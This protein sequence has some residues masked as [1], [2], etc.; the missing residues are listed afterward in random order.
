[1]SLRWLALALV[2]VPAVAGA[3]DDC[4][5]GA[6]VVGDDRALASLRDATETTCPCASY[7]GG[8]GKNRAAY[9]AC[10]RGVLAKATDVRPE[11]R[12]R[13]SAEQRSTTCGTHKVACGRANGRKDA[14]PTCRITRAGACRATGA[15]GTDTACPQETACTEVVDWTAGTCDDPRTHGRYAAG[16]TVITWTKDSIASPGTPRPLDTVIWYPAPAGSSP[17]G[18]EGG[19]MDAPVDPGGAPY[20][21]VLFSHGSCGYPEQSTFLTPLLATRGFIVVAPPHPGNTI[22]E[23]P[24]CGTAQA[25]AASFIER[26]HDM[27]FVLD[28]ILAAGNDPASPFHGMVDGSRVAMMGHSFGGLTTYLV[29]AIEPRVKVAVPLAPA[30]LGSPKLT[31]PSLTMFGTID[32]VV[33]R[34]P[35]VTAYQASSAPKMLVQIEDAGHYAFSDGCFPSAD[36]NPPTT[37]TQAEAHAFVLRYVVPFLQDMLAGDA[38]S[39]AFLTAPAVP[40]VDVQSAP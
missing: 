7:T 9:L 16:A 25:Q 11:C 29:Q 1:M 37:L 17:V 34:P 6:S 24:S 4:L 39:A 10:A 2:L 8:K 26:P 32:S 27:V 19:V 3:A 23:L 31:V 14:P 38:R 5:T 35:I 22:H 20:P 12:K 40:G 13:A 28:Q 18:P 30:A 33:S 15:R 21:V 36:C